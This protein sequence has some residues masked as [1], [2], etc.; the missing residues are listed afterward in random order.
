MGLL[1]VIAGAGC[2]RR[3]TDVQRATRAGMLLLNNGAEPAELDPQLATGVPEARVLEALF[4]G[5]TRLN[6]EDLAVEPGVAERW[7]TSP[8]GRV[9]T[10]HLRADAR[11]S[12]G[13]PVTAEDFVAAVRRLLTPSLGSDLVQEMYYLEGAEDFYHG[14]EKDFAR[15]GVRAIDAHTVEYR[16]RLPKPFFLQSVSQ[17]AWYPIPRHVIDRFD[18][19]GRRDSGWTRPENIVGNGPFTL[20]EWRPRQFLT[21]ERSETYWNRE[22]VRLNSVRFFPIENQAADEQAFR[23]GQLHKTHVLPANKVE[24]WRREDPDRLWSVPRSGTYFYA[25]NVRRPPFD[26]VRVR[27]AFALTVDRE[28]LTKH[29]LKTGEQPAYHFVVDGTAGYVSRTNLPYDP[30]EARRLLA[31]AGYPEGRGFPRVSILYNTAERHRTI[32]E[33]V[34]QMWRNELGIEVGLRNEEWGVYLASMDAGNFDLVRSGL[35][36]A[37][38]DAWLFLQS[39]TTGFGF[40]RTGWSNREYDGLVAKLEAEADP[41]RREELA[42]EAEALLMREVPI[43]PFHFY[44]ENYLVHEDVHGWADNLVEVHPLH[45]AWLD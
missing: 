7:D 26:D 10:F 38:Y 44:R 37:P 20:R 41:Q 22:T 13:T 11:W 14:R 21:V 25:F 35:L 29:V 5:L 8:D 28:T 40:N 12:D 31:E 6:P 4:E 36:I 2:A 16:L 17:R 39:F 32:A 33:A 27:R 30:A 15:V 45:R 42:Q 23:A 9:Y 24:V 3:E 19:W 1:V 18:A 34:Q 43:V